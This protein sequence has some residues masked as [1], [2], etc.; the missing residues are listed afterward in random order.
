MVNDKHDSR[1]H[2]AKVEEIDKLVKLGTFEVVPEVEISQKGTVLQSRFVLTIK[3]HGEPTEY[4]KARLYILG[5]LDPEKP[6]VVNQAPTVLESSTRLLI[7]LIASFEFLLLSRDIT[8]TFIQCKD[9]LKRDVYV[10]PPKG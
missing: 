3:N 10:R 6:K 2:D 1:F 5:H 7:S 9:K 8:L 4:F